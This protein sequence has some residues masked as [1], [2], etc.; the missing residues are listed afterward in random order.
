MIELK[1][2]K[3][4]YNIGKE[5][6]VEVLHGINLSVKEKETLAI[7]GVSGSGKTTLLNIIGCIDSFTSGEYILDG[8][9]ISNLSNKELANIRNR[10]IGF[11]LQDYGLIM[12]ETV[13]NN[14]EIPL[15][16][17]NLVKRKDYKKI[18]LEVTNKLNISKY[19]N[20][21]VGKLSGGEKQRVSI[22]RAIINNPDIIL[23]DE[24]TSSLD[25]S[26]ANEIIDILLNLNKEGKTI[27]LVTHDINIAKKMSRIEYI[28]DG[29]ISSN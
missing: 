17:N 25:S 10:K 27:I 4:S 15:V 1:D 8:K 3:K 23:A 14:I 9:I 13:K 21:K 7:M 2:I 16:F 5:N 28:K 22:A 18:I 11:I 6:E 24:P 12:N 19:L 26:L 29:L 20:Q